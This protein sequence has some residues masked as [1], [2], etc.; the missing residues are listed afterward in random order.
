VAKKLFSKVYTKALEWTY[1][2]SFEV[3]VL[4]NLQLFVTDF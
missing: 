3:T 4:H 2:S 1:I